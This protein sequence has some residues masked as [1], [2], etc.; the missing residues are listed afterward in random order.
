M[1]ADEAREAARIAYR[2]ALS[3]AGYGAAQAD[4]LAAAVLASSLVGLD[5]GP[6][7][8][9]IERLV[10]TVVRGPVADRW[11]GDVEA[12][13]RFGPRPVHAPPPPHL[14]GRDGERGWREAQRRWPTGGNDKPA[15]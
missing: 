14:R 5:G 3:T 15:A 12:E 11:P 8:D 6:D 7:T 13:R 1:S 9:R 10:A 2:Q 4:E